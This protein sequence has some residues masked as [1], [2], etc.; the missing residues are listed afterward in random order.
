M[1]LLES[2]GLSA[3]RASAALHYLADHL[4]HQLHP[5]DDAVAIFRA[6]YRCGV[7][8]SCDRLRRFAGAQVTTVVIDEPARA[9]TIPQAVSQ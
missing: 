1:E 9:M 6:A 2:M 5:P 4:S 7:H 3:E 8:D